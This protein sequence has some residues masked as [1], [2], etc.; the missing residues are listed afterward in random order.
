MYA[1]KI[2]KNLIPT[3]TKVSRSIPRDNERKPAFYSMDVIQLKD[4]E[5]EVWKLVSGRHGTE[6]V[7]ALG[8]SCHHIIPQDTLT[9]FYV[10]CKN[11][12][13]RSVEKALENWETRAIASADATKN[14]RDVPAN[15]SHGVIAYSACM[16]MNGNI[17]IGP[18]PEYR[19]DD[20]DDKF[21][22]GGMR[23]RDIKCDKNSKRDGSKRDGSEWDGFKSNDIMLSMEVMHRDMEVLV[24][25]YKTT[26]DTMANTMAVND[27][28]HRRLP[29][30]VQLGVNFTDAQIKKII[31]ILSSLAELAAER[32]TLH[33][34]TLSP[35]GKSPA[36]N[37]DDWV[38]VGQHKINGMENKYA[39][40]NTML[41]KYKSLNNNALSDKDKYFLDNFKKYIDTTKANDSDIL[42]SYRTMAKW[43]FMALLRKYTEAYPKSGETNT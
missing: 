6:P 20:L 15:A 42:S 35:Q 37:L 12:T 24:S 3:Q 21:D 33:K 13:N 41:V 8:L 23:W 29:R 10:V 11:C 30:Q 18:N 31:K 43:N 9:Y 1:D 28:Q 5:S 39:E 27:P 16:W 34:N 2:K 40:F 32:N 19:M 38:S 26:I 36:Y 4:A 17:F 7:S 25:N 14:K 22:Y